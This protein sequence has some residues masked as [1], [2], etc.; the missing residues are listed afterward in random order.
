MIFLTGSVLVLGTYLLADIR[1]AYRVLIKIALLI[2]FP[3]ILYVFNFYEKIE[4]EKLQGFF[5]KWR[6][7]KNIGKNIKGFLGK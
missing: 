2:S 4:L 7:L 3:F 1:L 5:T 6:D